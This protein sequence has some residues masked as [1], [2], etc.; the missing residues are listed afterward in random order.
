MRPIKNNLTK[1]GLFTGVI[2]IELS[3]LFTILKLMPHP[4]YIQGETNNLI[5]NPAVYS[6]LGISVMLAWL[7]V[8][9]FYYSWSIYFYNINLG[10]TESDWEKIYKRISEK[11]LLKES[12]VEVPDEDL[13]EPDEN[14]YKDETFGLPSGTVRGTIALTLLAGGISM[15]FFSFCPFVTEQSDKFE[16]A[17]DFFKTAFLMMVAF[18]FGSHSLKILKNSSQEDTSTP[19]MPS[20]KKTVSQDVCD[21]KEEVKLAEKPL[22][23]PVIVEQKEKLSVEVE[24]VANKKLSETEIADS[25]KTNNLEVALIKAV[26]EVESR[27][28]GFLPDGRPKI[29]FEGHIFW[30]QLKEKGLNPANFALNHPDIVYQHWTNQHYLGGEKEYSRLEKAKL[31]DEEAALKSTSWGLFQIMGFNYKAAGFENVDDFVKAQMVSEK[32]QLDSFINFIKFKKIDTA[33]REHRWK[34]F[35]HAYNG[36]KFEVNKYDIKLEDAYDKYCRM[37]HTLITAILKRTKS[38]TKQTLGQLDVFSGEQVLFTCKTLELPWKDNQKNIS[39]IP[40]GKYKVIKRENERFNKHFL[41]Q[42]VPNRDYIC[43]YAGNYISQTHGGILAGLE[44]KDIDKDG[45]LDV[46]SSRIAIEK[47]YSILPE[48][49]ELEITSK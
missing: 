3:I 24:Q 15:L 23:A 49:F 9:L 44:H 13:K 5:I 35:A 40:E 33:L 10:I 32:N 26:L 43:L 38:N 1:T 45:F 20:E 12:G 25:A 21:K 27:G 14:P 22:L 37:S 18:Y 19:K 42:D 48:K 2:L 31:I 11:R 17:F 4:F 46:S 36:P 28:A 7:G 30:N 41:F 16:K 34:D 47:L 8:L 6:F 29:L 39:C